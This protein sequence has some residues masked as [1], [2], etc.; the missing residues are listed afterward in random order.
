MAADVTMFACIRGL[1]FLFCNPPTNRYF[2]DR[3]LTDF[4][5][6][7]H[8]SNAYPWFGVPFSSGRLEQIFVV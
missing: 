6:P 7:L 4:V 5:I 3:Q 8:R 1:G 2:F